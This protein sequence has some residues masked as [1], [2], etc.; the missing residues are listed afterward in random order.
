MNIKLVEALADVI[1]AL[2]DEDYRLF[3]KVLTD[4]IVCKTSGDAGGYACIRDTRIALWTIISLKQQGANEDELSLDFPELTHF[5]FMAAQTYYQTYR[6]EIN[7][8]ITSYSQSQR[9]IIRD[10]VFKR[11]QPGSAAGQ[12]IIAPDFEDPVLGFED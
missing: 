6:E 8:I 7:K 2:P 11:R 3:Q 1:L 5:D 4:K 12:I 9:E 10:P